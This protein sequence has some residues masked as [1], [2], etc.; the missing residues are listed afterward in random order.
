[1]MR[2]FEARGKVMV[3][4]L[5]AVRLSFPGLPIMSG[6]ICAFVDAEWPVTESADRLAERFVQTRP[7]DWVI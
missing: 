3:E 6:E 4:L 5:Q 1:M 2:D 7:H